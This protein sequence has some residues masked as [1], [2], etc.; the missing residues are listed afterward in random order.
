MLQATNSGLRTAANA[1]SKWVTTAVDDVNDAYNV[2]SSAIRNFTSDARNSLAP[3]ANSIGNTVTQLG[4]S[5]Y[6]VSAG[7]F[8]GSLCQQ[9]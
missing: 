5:I 7:D 4:N 3:A 8:L 1:T 6:N 9:T 2:S